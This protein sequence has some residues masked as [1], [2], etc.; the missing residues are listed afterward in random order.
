M[1]T[2]EKWSIG[3]SIVSLCASGITAIAVL[4]LNLYAS[5]GAYSSSLSEAGALCQ[6]WVQFVLVEQRRG[7]AAGEDPAEVDAKLT[8]L[9]HFGAGTALVPDPTGSASTSVSSSTPQP[10]PTSTAVQ[11][12]STEEAVNLAATCADPAI[13]RRIDL[14]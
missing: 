2:A 10:T 12:P 8:T 14:H 6:Q 9:G 4:M 3:I 1:T 13:V 7:D 5:A 11:L